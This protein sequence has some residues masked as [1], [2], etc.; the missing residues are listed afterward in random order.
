MDKDGRNDKKWNAVI[1]M[2]TQM[3]SKSSII[4]QKGCELAEMANMLGVKPVHCLFT[5]GT[6][7]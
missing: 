5:P 6:G 4:K 1:L 7:L 3:E 2:S